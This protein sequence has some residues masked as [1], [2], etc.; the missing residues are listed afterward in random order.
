MHPSTFYPV[1]KRFSVRKRPHGENLLIFPLG[2]SHGDEGFESRPIWQAP[3]L[4]DHAIPKITWET[5]SKAHALR[6]T[7]LEHSSPDGVFHV[8]F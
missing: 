2:D 8:P 4:F 1:R 5:G 6:S 7:R 3:H